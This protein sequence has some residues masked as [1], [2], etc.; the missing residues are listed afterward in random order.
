[1]RQHYSA[2]GYSMIS[3]SHKFSI[4][5]VVLFNQVLIFLKALNNAS[6]TMSLRQTTDSAVG[7]NPG[8]GK[9]G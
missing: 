9:Q 5:K 1:M 7:T 2:K 3:I 6:D 4:N 8:K